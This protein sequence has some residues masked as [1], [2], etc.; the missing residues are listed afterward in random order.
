[1]K[2]V[3]AQLVAVAA[4]G[5]V[6]AIPGPAHAESCVTVPVG[7]SGFTLEA[8]GE[9]VRIPAIASASVC[10]QIPGTPGIPW[11]KTE[12]G[13][14]SVV[15]TGG[16]ATGGHVALR[17]V[18]DGSTRSVTAPL[19]ATGGGGRET[20]LFGVGSPYARPD[21]AVKLHADQLVPSPLPTAPP[22]PTTG[23]LPT[24]PPLPTLPPVPS[25]P[26]TPEPN[27][28]CPTASQCIP[29]GGELQG[30][31]DGFYEFLREDVAPAVRELQD[32]IKEIVDAISIGCTPVTC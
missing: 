26:P 13:G 4:V 16:S 20:C 5:A 22:I 18:A 14:A 24:R 32:R 10:Y 23:P 3:L 27:P 15:V 6:I 25:A 9:E 28:L 29:Y 2:K 1:M 30:L 21:C 8:A 19:P 11:V 12:Y 7:S 17:Y 31:V